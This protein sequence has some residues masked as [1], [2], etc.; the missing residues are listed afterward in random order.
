MPKQN[1]IIVIDSKNRDASSTSSSNFNYTLDI[2]QY[3]KYTK[4]SLLNIEVD[5]T[6]YMHDSTAISFL[7]GEFTGPVSF[8]VTLATRNYTASQLAAELA[9]KMTAG[10]LAVNGWTYTVNYLSYEN[11]FQIY[12]GNAANEFGLSNFENSTIGAYISGTTTATN[13]S[14]GYWSSVYP[15]RLQR[16]RTLYLYTN[17]LENSY[18]SAIPI[19]VASYQDNDVIKYQPDTDSFPFELTSNQTNN[20]NFSLTDENKKAVNLNNGEIRLIMKL[21]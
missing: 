8:S 12:S 11:K 4:A 21:S 9:T 20:F 10:S 1:Q 13:S 7:V 5:K 6:Y 19:F 14:S 3:N 15:I 17:I 16:Y 2:G 18:S